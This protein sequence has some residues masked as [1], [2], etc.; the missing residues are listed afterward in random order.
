MAAIQQVSTKT[1]TLR[2]VMRSAAFTKGHKDALHGKPFDYDAYP[3]TNDQWAYERGRLFAMVYKYP[4]KDG[5]TITY[6]AL[7]AFHSAWQDNLIM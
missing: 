4:V 3:D 2:S 6:D 1:C 7:Y 5:K